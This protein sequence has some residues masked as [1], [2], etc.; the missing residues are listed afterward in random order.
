MCDQAVRAIASLSFFSL[1]FLSF[2]PFFFS[3]LPP[4]LSVGIR[5][6]PLRISGI[7]PQR[8][9]QGRRN[10]DHRMPLRADCI[11]WLSLFLFSFSPP[12]FP[13]FFFPSL[14]WET[15]TMQVGRSG[16]RGS[17]IGGMVIAE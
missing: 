15:R 9:S 6:Q 8:R 13:F 11:V 5:L 14:L 3:L 1:P 2:L 10:P 17:G 4:K 16:S 12:P 7:E